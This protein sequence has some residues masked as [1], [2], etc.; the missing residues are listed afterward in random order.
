MATKGGSQN[1]QWLQEED[2]R[3]TNATRGESQSD[4]WLQEEEHRVINSYKMRIT[5]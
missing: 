1:D 4:Q 2:H 3:M 5:E